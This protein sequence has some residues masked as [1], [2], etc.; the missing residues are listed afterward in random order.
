MKTPKRIGLIGLLVFAAIFAASC[1]E[2]YVYVPVKRTYSAPSGV[3]SGGA[4]RGP[5]SEPVNFQGGM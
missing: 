1:Q 2:T 3:T 4:I 5:A